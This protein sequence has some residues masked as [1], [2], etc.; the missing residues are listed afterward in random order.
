MVEAIKHL[1]TGSLDVDIP[2]TLICSADDR[3]V[4]AVSD[5]RHTA[6][7]IP[8]LFVKCYQEQSSRQLSVSSA[9]GIIIYMKTVR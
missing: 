7:L 9:S 1:A 2:S 3:P 5:A 4:N 6:L 8:C